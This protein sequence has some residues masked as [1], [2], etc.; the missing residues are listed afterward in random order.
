MTTS[1]GLIRFNETTSRLSGRP[2]DTLASPRKKHKSD[3]VARWGEALNRMLQADEDDN[4]GLP[5]MLSAHIEYGG[6]SNKG[7]GAPNGL[8]RHDKT[9]RGTVAPTGW[10]ATIVEEKPWRAP[11]ANFAYELPGELVLAKEK[12]ANTDY[13]P[14]QLLEYVKPRNP[15]EKPKYRV[16]FYDG[17]T[18]VLEEGMFYATSDDGFRTCTLGRDRFNYE[19]DDERDDPLAADT[20]SDEEEPVSRASSPIPSALPPP[21]FEFDLTL[22]EQFDYIKPVLAAVVEGAYEPAQELHDAFMRGEA[23][24]RKVTNTVS[25]RGSLRHHEVEELGRLVRRWARRQEKR[26]ALPAAEV[27]LVARGPAIADGG[28]G[29]VQHESVSEAEEP[30]PSSF[31]T[32]DAGEYVHLQGPSSPRLLDDGADLQRAIAAAALCELSDASARKL[33][34]RP[35]VESKSNVPYGVAH[36]TEMNGSTIIGAESSVCS[37]KDRETAIHHPRTAYAD[38]SDLDKLTYCTDVLLREAVL[39]LLL[40]RSRSRTV[41]ELQAPE[42]ERRLHNLALEQAEETYWVHDIIRMKR[43]AEGSML[44]PSPGRKPAATSSSRSLRKGGT[45]SRPSLR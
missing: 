39:Q 35:L 36:N 17:T 14:A 12:R 30:P 11:S 25:L 13:W 38:L 23:S 43:A 22:S 31:A 41:P 8:P 18:K 24:R 19:L 2:T 44:P 33:K 20:P 9:Q 27:Q 32:T 15:K 1:R 42:E 21:A 40:W 26:K 37:S 10:E 45:R 5:A 4:D 16:G 29:V 6:G 3:V 34:P 28:S 7:A